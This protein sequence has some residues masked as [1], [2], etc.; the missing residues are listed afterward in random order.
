MVLPS[1]NSPGSINLE[2]VPNQYYAAVNTHVAWANWFVANRINVVANEL[3]CQ[4]SIPQVLATTS[5][6]LTTL[7][8]K[9]DRRKLVLRCLDAGSWS[10]RSGNTAYHCWRAWL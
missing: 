2:P 7:F 9:F 10:N 1:E 4:P 5:G 8:A 3:I 6:A